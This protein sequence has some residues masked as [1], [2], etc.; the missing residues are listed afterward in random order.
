MV[1]FIISIILIYLD[2]VFDVTL[3]ASL[4]ATS[5]ILFTI[6]H[7]NAS[8]VQY[9]VGGY[10]MGIL[11]GSLCFYG[12][13]LLPFIAPST[14]G[15]IAIGCSMFIMVIFNF[16]HPPAAAVASVLYLTG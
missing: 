5:F 12:L 3:V 1:I 10:M 14:W 6:P 9:I 7:K 4:G 15:A 13:Q 8:R 2:F 16:E 11:V